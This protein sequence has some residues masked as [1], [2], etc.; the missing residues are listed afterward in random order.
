MFRIGICV[1]HY[2]ARLGGLL[3]VWNFQT[4]AKKCASNAGSRGNPSGCSIFLLV[5]FQ[6]DPDLVPPVQNGLPV[7]WHQIRWQAASQLDC[8]KQLPNGKGRVEFKSEK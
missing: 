4:L 6:R 7:L 8:N 2:H 3:L 5:F 1:S